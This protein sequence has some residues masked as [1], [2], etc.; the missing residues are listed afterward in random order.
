MKRSGSAV[1]PLHSG[2][3]P[4]WLVGRMKSF[5]GEIV[6]VIIDEYGRDEQ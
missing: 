6:T 5:A 3:A 4:D 1:L 2:H